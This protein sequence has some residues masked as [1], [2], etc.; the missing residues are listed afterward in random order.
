MPRHQRQRVRL[1]QSSSRRPRG[2][3]SMRR[4]AEGYGLIAFPAALAMTIGLMFNGLNNLSGSA[5]ACIMSALL[6][7]G[8]II[9]RPPG[10]D[11]WQ[12][13]ARILSPVGLAILWL[14]LH[15]SGFW[16]LFGMTGPFEP[17]LFLPGIVGIAGAICAFLGGAF[18]A[19]NRRNVEQTIDMLIILMSLFLAI[20]LLFANIDL[21]GLLDYWAVER[22]G[23]FSGTI[24]NINT[25]ACICG[26]VLLLSVSKA[27]DALV[28]ARRD[29][30]MRD[31]GGMS[32][33]AMAILIA[34]FAGLGTAARLPIMAS[35]VLMLLL[36]FWLMRREIHVTRPQK[37]L[38]AFV[39][40]TAVLAW[41]IG[42]DAVVRRLAS[43]D[44]AL[45][46]RTLMLTHY[47]DVAMNSPLVGYGLSSFPSVNSFFMTDLEAM[48][49][50]HNVNSPHNILLQLLLVGGIPYAILILVAAW[51]VVRFW[52]ARERAGQ[53]SRIELGI[54]AS[55]LLILSCAMID[56]VLDIPA[57]I[58]LSLFLAGLL[59]GCGLSRRPSGSTELRTIPA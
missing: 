11:E 49:T 4:S 51:R 34:L 28:P 20:G 48:L 32:T 40:V 42:S 46:V 52:I 45:G 29:L 3:G 1:R 37:F 5:A 35:L 23:R 12:H 58:N 24:G 36:L 55:L 18:V 10:L 27:A 8:L 50:L 9:A 19:A 30:A 54:A 6:L 21:N 43:V 16:T 14:L 33:Y 25:T 22:Q 44:T 59:H 57:T 53:V 15:Q 13:C 7:A 17:D 31:A 2:G 56:I 41:M 38:L 39:G 47:L 26:I